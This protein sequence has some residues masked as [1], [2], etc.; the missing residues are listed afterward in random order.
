MLIIN[1]INSVTFLDMSDEHVM[2]LFYSLFPYIYL[3]LYINIFV[4]SIY[5]FEHKWVNIFIYI[6][7]TVSNWTNNLPFSYTN[8]IWGSSHFSQLMLVY[9][10]SY[11]CSILAFTYILGIQIQ[12][13]TVG[14]KLFY[15]LNH[16][17]N[18]LIRTK[19]IRWGNCI[20]HFL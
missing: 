20:V 3:Y 8:K 6:F 5:L 12:V 15:Q 1:M 19:I 11:S 9:R 17:N 14:W 2:I 18:C 7:E 13:S 4:K 16:F 10:S